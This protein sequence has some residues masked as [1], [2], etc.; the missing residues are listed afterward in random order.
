MMPYD[1][2][3]LWDGK[4]DPLVWCDSPRKRNALAWTN[5][6]RRGL[7]FTNFNIGYDWTS[8]R[9]KKGGMDEIDLGFCLLCIHV[10]LS[11]CGFTQQLGEYKEK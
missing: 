1:M 7:K 2:L 10:E 11:A 5:D 8:D 6:R 9:T 3:T 4:W